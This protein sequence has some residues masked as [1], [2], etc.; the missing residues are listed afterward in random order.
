M[1]LINGPEIGVTFDLCCAHPA[2][3]EHN[4]LGEHILNVPEGVVYLL[5]VPR[6]A[7]NKNFGCGAALSKLKNFDDAA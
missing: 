1:N 6:G 3:T 2:P 7:H 5:D 4:E